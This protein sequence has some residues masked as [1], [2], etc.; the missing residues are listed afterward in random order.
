MRPNGLGEIARREVGGLEFDSCYFRCAHFVMHL[1][2]QKFPF[3]EQFVAQR[4]SHLFCARAGIDN[5]SRLTKTNAE[6]NLDIVAS[7]VGFLLTG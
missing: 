7:L 4:C 2:R 1:F 3:P 5:A 6:T